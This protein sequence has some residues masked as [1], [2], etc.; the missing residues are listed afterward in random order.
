[1]ANRLAS[2]SQSGRKMGKC[3]LWRRAAVQVL[4]N[5]NFVGVIMITSLPLNFFMLL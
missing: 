2:E 4:D 5:A 1:M 3:A